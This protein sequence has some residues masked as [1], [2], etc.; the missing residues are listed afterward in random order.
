VS[1]KSD[2]AAGL[3]QILDD[4]SIA[5][6]DASGA[7]TSTQVGVTLNVIPEA[8]DQIVAITVYDVTDH[9]ELNDSTL[10]VQIRLRGTRD[11]RSVLDRDD[12]I[13]NVFEGMRE[14]TINGVAL[15]IMA[16][17]SSLPLGRDKNDRH[18]HSSTYYA[19][20]AHPTRYRTD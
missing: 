15:V 11:P 10:G 16:R 3:A 7:Y 13:F 17:Q 1:V 5:T 4:E 18:E 20:I 9:A 14:T 19:Q 8:P 6:W 2:F 12:A